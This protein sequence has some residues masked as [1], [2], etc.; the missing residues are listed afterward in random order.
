[1]S[2]EEWIWGNKHRGGGGDPLQQVNL[3]ALALN[4]CILL[5]STRKHRCIDFTINT[6]KLEL[7]RE[8]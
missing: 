7:L 6:N 5:C 4:I 1:M 2:D 3:F 8:F